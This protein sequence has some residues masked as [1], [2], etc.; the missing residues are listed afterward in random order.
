MK[1]KVTVNGSVYDVDVEVE[2]TR[3]PAL[4]AINVGGFGGGI[5][6]PTT[7]KA[8]ASSSSSLTA[9]IAGTVVKVLVEPGQEVKADETLLILEAM[10]METEVTAPKDGTIAAVAVGVG[11][12]VA[13]GQVLVEWAEQE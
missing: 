3:R 6:A 13:S 5:P 12:A 11:D 2:E 8:P 7:A 4:G 10:K 9:N 1:L